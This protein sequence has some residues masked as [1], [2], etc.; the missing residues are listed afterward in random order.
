MSCGRSFALF[1]IFPCGMLCLSAVRIR[2]VSIVFAVCMLSGIS[3]LSSAFSI[4]C[5]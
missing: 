2:L 3:V 4:S 1:L 5:V